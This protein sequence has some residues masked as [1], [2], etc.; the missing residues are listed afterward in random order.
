MNSGTLI[1]LD[2]SIRLLNKTRGYLRNMEAFLS[3]A[4]GA[5]SI[6]L[7]TLPHAD[8]ALVLKMLPL[9]GY[10]GKDRVLWPLYRLV[11][12]VSVDEQVRRSAAIQLGL[13][14]SLS[15]DPARLKSEL[16]EN[17]NHADASVRSGCAL[18]LGWEGNG[19]AVNS[20][21]VHLQDPDRD[22]QAAV[23]AALSSVGDRRVF[24]HLV[25]HLESGSLEEQRIIL[26]N[27]WRFS[28]KTP[29]VEV[30]YLDRLD[31]LTSDLRVDALSALGMLPLTTAI[32]EA[33]RRLLTD[34]NPRIRY[35]VIENLAAIDP[36]DYAL[37]SA[38]LQILVA[39]KND[40]V[41]Q[42]AIR[43]LAKR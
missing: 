13:A 30:V 20:L 29:G 10:A 31:R 3:D 35:Q 5:V 42:A 9:L 4:S 34:E 24:D 18:A 15:D 23:V 6:L 8:T 25:D 19:S 2:R 11:T 43:L 32:L 14:A 33:Y 41:R 37:L 12:E 27:L 40:R 7:D 16:I 1:P 17:L 38:H 36:A 28:E 39:D 22:V 21:L 26:L